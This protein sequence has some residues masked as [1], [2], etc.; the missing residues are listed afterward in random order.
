MS[1]TKASETLK[2]NFRRAMISYTL[3]TT[4]IGATDLNFL[5]AMQIKANTHLQVMH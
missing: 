2:V 3:N 1:V 5:L 4:Q